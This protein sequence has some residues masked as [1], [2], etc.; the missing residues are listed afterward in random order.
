M[1]NPS[2][3]EL[4]CFFFQ[5]KLRIYCIRFF[6][7]ISHTGKDISYAN[8]VDVNNALPYLMPNRLRPKNITAVVAA[9]MVMIRP[10]P[11]GFLVDP[12]SIG[13]LMFF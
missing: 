12:S 10:S 4:Q 13:F 9:T 7:H 1:I 6:N 2:L 8:D 5:S 3:I 11:I